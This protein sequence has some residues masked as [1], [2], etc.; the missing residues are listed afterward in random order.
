MLEYLRVWCQVWKTV[1]VSKLMQGGLPRG[2]LLAPSQGPKCEVPS[3]LGSQ[4]SSWLP[5]FSHT[6]GNAWPCNI[7]TSSWHTAT[8]CYTNV[9]TLHSF[10][11]YWEKAAEGY[12]GLDGL[13]ASES[14]AEASIALAIQL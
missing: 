12:R 1:H 7:T 2:A 9:H 14:K 10:C 5:S 6:Q 8:A 4:H 13:A 3:I 11:K